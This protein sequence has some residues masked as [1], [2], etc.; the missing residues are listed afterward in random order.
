[1]RNGRDD[2]P[3]TIARDKWQLAGNTVTLGGGFEPGRTYEL[4]YTAANPPVSGLGFVAVRDT[5]TW[6]KYAGDAIASTR[7]AVA[8]GASQSGRFLRTFLYNGFN[9]DEREC[10]QL[11][12]HGNSQ[13]Q[14]H[15]IQ[16]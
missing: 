1:M 7:Y 6:V 16:E 8:F 9:T 12:E 5:A 10:L 13:E 4:A 2:A 3:I 11:G 14:N 15:E